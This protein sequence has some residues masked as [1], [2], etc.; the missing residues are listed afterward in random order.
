MSH[1]WLA[2]SPL[3]SMIWLLLCGCQGNHVVR[4]TAKF[5]AG[6]GFVRHEVLVDGTPRPVW[7][8]IPKNYRADLR[9]PAI[10]FL[11]G[12]FEAGS[13]GQSSLS[14]GLGPVIANS[15]DTWQFITIFPQSN[16]TWRGPDRERLVIA[17]LDSVEKRWSVDRDRVTL[18]GLSFGALGVWEIGARNPDRFSALVPVAAPRATEL[19]PRLSLFP[20]WAFNFRSDLVVSSNGTDEMCRQ[21]TARGGTARQ[22]KF[23]GVGHDCWDRAVAESN[24]VDWMLHQRISARATTVATPAF[25]DVR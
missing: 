6:T 3:L 13:D 1:R 17:A 24:L 12:L 20:V 10:V 4:S 7:V 11:H 9:Y 18:A 5:H 2:L 19:A 14:A 15:P 8:F 16:G 22:T 21:I 23:D 25:A